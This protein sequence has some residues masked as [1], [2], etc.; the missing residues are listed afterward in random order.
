[1]R[2]DLGHSLCTHHH[3]FSPY[4]TACTATH[5]ASYTPTAKQTVQGRGWLQLQSY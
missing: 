1:V 5:P 3:S 4:T 2:L